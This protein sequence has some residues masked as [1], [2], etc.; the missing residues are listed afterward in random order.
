MQR[1][2]SSKIS[3]PDAVS[4]IVKV[5]YYSIH[6]YQFFYVCFY[7]NCSYIFLATFLQTIR[8][9]DLIVLQEVTDTSL[10][11]TKHLLSELNDGLDENE[12]YD[13]IISPKIGP[14][15]YKEQ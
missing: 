7:I 1:L 15:K 12:I 8:K 5:R 2:G 11:A 4:V 9:Y 13:M 6:L 14:A 10:E 3:K